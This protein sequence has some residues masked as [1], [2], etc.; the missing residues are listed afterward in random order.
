[1]WN[2]FCDFHIASPFLAPSRFI[3]VCVPYSVWERHILLFHRYDAYISLSIA[4]PL[5]NCR[6]QT[7][8]RHCTHM[9]CLNFNKPKSFKTFNVPSH[10]IIFLEYNET[11]PCLMGVRSE[12]YVRS[13]EIWYLIGSQNIYQEVADCSRFLGAICSCKFLSSSKGTSRI[14][15]HFDSDKI[16]LI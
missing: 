6:K 10:V 4:T 7:F 11:K 12:K 14:I 8:F 9:R 13:H 5:F 16:I 1:M 15:G 2:H 3:W